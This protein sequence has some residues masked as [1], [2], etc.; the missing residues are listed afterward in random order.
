VGGDWVGEIL[1]SKGGGNNRR[2]YLIIY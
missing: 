2:Y 1:Y